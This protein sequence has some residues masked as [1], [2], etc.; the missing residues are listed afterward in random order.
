MK[1]TFHRQTQNAVMK[2]RV[3]TS[4]LGLLGGTK[5]PRAT[6]LCKILLVLMLTQLT[7]KKR[8]NK[9]SKGQKVEAFFSIPR[10]RGQAHLRA[11]RSPFSLPA[12]PLGSL[13]QFRVLVLA[14]HPEDGGKEGLQMRLL[15]RDSIP[16]HPRSQLSSCEQSKTYQWTYPAVSKRTA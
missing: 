5:T 11:F 9:I 6:A 7:V 16:E 1:P 8:K 15:G 3:H 14:P 2:S 10:Q 4:A 12:A 13:P